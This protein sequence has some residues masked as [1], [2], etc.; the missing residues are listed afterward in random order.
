[1]NI[2]HN[3]N[4]WYDETG[5]K[6][7]ED[8]K[9]ATKKQVRDELDSD[10]K[11]TGFEGWLKKFISKQF[12][13]HSGVVHV[14]QTDSQDSDTVDES[15]EHGGEQLAD[16]AIDLAINSLD[17]AIAELSDKLEHLKEERE[18]LIKKRQK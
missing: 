13:K 4:G 12:D 8:E 7:T 15:T 17:L 9:E 11:D 16:E 3:D 6:L 5:R 18:K 10:L 14:N 2:K 1:M